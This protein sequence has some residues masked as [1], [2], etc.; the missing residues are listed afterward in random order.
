MACAP[1]QEE[2]LTTLSK[3]LDARVRQISGAV[4]DIGEARLFLIAALSLLD[5]LDVQTSKQNAARAQLTDQ[6]V[7]AL[8]ADTTAR[9]DALATRL[10]ATIKST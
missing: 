1:G 4:G 9:I 7:Q 10:G 2:R 5:E 6:K 8:L 3:D